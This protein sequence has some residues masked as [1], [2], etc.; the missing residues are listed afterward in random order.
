MEMSEKNFRYV[1]CPGAQPSLDHM[2]VYEQIYQCWEEV[3]S[4]TF[5]ELKVPRSLVSDAFTR[6]D[7]VGALFYKDKC[8]G[9][10]F[11]RWTNSS[12]AVFSKDSYFANW[13]ADH[14]KYLCSR[15]N[16]IIVCSN[17]TIHPDARGLQLG[18]ATR[19]ILL[20][21]I[22]ETF[23]NSD[24]D[25]MTGATRL[26]RKVNEVCERWGAEQIATHIPSGFGDAEVNLVG[27]FKDKIN[28]H[29][30]PLLK[31]LT[32]RLWLNRTEI[33]RI[34]VNEDYQQDRKAA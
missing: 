9:M 2:Q 31:A 1:M 14:L 10:S 3:W 25:A 5:S 28:N 12:S 30:V 20:G 11:F 34:H 23:M 29:P 13:S 18:V 16:K 27:F 21:M 19:D 17:Y 4:K 24:A 26:D 6:Q 32:S 7:Y 22:V 8:I 15:G 33:P